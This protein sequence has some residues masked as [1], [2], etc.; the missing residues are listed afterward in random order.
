MDEIAF[1]T[2]EQVIEI[3][4]ST[5]PMSGPPDEDKLGGALFRIETLA[6]YE[7]CKDI[8]DFAAMYLIAIAKAHAFNDANKRTAFQ[9]AS[10]FLLGNGY[11][12]NA[13]FELVKLTVLA[14]MGDAQL[15]ETAFALRIL[16]DYRNDIVAEHDYVAQ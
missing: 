8:F 15:N 3:Q 16:S 14:A 5:L 4:R 9:A 13:S 10:I 7:G 2:T 11:E 6:E 1:L 12:L